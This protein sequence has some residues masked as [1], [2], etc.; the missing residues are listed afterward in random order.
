MCISSFLVNK[1]YKP[2]KVCFLISLH[3]FYFVIFPHLVAHCTA[4]KIPILSIEF[5]FIL[6]SQFFPVHCIT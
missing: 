1:F 2:Q 6:L 3:F 5:H 4:Q